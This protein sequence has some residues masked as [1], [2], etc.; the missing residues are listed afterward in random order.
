M[1]KVDKQDSLGYINLDYFLQ[2]ERKKVY[3]SELLKV[4]IC[5]LEL[6]SP[7]ILASGILGVSH[8]SLINIF[9]IGAGA[10]TTKS[11]G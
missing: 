4:N 3:D 10:V 2:E 6:K 9:K 7:V 11:V 1:L 5:N 8:S